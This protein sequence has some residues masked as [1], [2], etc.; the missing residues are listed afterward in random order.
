GGGA[1]TAGVFWTSHGGPDGRIEDWQ[2]RRFGPTDLGE[3]LSCPD[4]KMFVM[5]ACYVANNADKWQKALGEGVKIFGWGAP[6]TGER[7]ADFLRQD[8]TTSKGFDDL[9]ALHLGAARK[10]AEGPLVEAVELIGKLGQRLAGHLPSY[11][12]LI[13]IVSSRCVVKPTKLDAAPN[14]WGFLIPRFVEGRPKPRTQGVRTAL[15]GDWVYV[16]ST[17]GPYSDLI[18]LTKALKLISDNTFT[19][20]FLS[21]PPEGPP[22]IIVSATS[23]LRGL[24]S[25]GFWGMIATV[26]DIA[27]EL[28]DA[29]FGSDDR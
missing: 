3:G 1:K 19:R 14:L 10:A 28:E 13:D 16:S 25:G 17:V 27:D 15:F 22:F 5:S 29:Y 4:L 6:I 2:G 24:T 9:L 26:G 11:E 23:T 8:E 21:K 7:A 18:D 20:V 12:A